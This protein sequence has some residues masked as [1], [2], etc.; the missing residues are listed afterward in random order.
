MDTT[1][2]MKMRW[3]M[4]WVM[5]CRVAMVAVAPPHSRAHPGGDMAVA[6]DDRL[7]PEHP[8]GPEL[9]AAMDDHPRPERLVVPAVTTG[10]LLHPE[11]RVVPAPAKQ[12]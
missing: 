11:L 6:M 9:V 5:T 12:A 10:D 1:K 2:G 3:E 8:A 4:T 7:R